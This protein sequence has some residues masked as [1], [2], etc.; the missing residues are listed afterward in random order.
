MATS[1]QAFQAKI[2][3]GTLKA[4]PM[5]VGLA[6]MP[7][8]IDLIRWRVPPGPRGNLGWVLSMGGVQVIP[9][10]TGNYI[11]ADNETDSIAVSGLPD[12]GAWQ[13]TGYNT[14]VNDHTVYLYFHVTPT[15]VGLAGGDVTAGFPLSDADLQSLW[16][17]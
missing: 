14:G 8:T 13:L 17:T 16:I 6:V 4:A 12:S 11:V 10:N 9:E 1:V 5:V 7:G 15:A 2:T 3:A